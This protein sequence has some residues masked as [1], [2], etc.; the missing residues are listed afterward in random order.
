[1]AGQKNPP[2]R[3]SL[4]FLKEGVPQSRLFFGLLADPVGGVGIS[5]G[6]KDDRLWDSDRSLRVVISAQSRTVYRGVI[7]YQD[8]ELFDKGSLLG[9]L[10]V[11]HERDQFFG[12]GPHSKLDQMTEVRQARSE[13]QWGWKTSPSGFYGIFSLGWFYRESLERVAL[14]Y[15]NERQLS[16]IPSLQA[17]WGENNNLKLGLKIFGSHEDFLSSHSFWGYDLT[18]QVQVPLLKKFRVSLV[19]RARGVSNQSPYGMLSDLGGN[20]SLP[21]VRAGR[22]KDTFGSYLLAALDLGLG[23]SWKVGSFGSFALLDADFKKS[24][25][26]KSLGGGGAFVEY[27]RE[28]FQSRLE[29]GHFAKET[30]IQ[31]G[32][33]WVFE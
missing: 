6:K 7:H 4:F 33:R 9:F 23:H 24:L 30:I 11:A 32:S 21:G 31:V 19:G 17:G 8:R 26:Q 2:D 1:L 10:L 5:I 14:D 25:K 15:L 12:L 22:F 16:L 18:G 3:R 20:L 29:L 13:G 27:G 28:P